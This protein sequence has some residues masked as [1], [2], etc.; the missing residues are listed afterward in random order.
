MLSTNYQYGFCGKI[1]VME[2]CYLTTHDLEELKTLSLNE[3]IDFLKRNPHLK[4]A[5][6]DSLTG[7]CMYQYVASGCIY[8]ELG[9]KAFDI[10]HFYKENQNINF[11]NRVHKIVEDGY[12]GK[13]I[14]FLK[15]G[16]P[17]H[18]CE[19]TPDEPG[20]IITNYLQSQKEC[21]IKLEE[22]E[23]FGLWPES[24]FGKLLKSDA[25]S[26]L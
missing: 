5:F 15:R 11:P 8:P 17:R 25:R 9:I 1:V 3:H 23:I 14:D 10:W 6:S 13:R 24:I 12:N 18:I 2:S 19:L 22:K 20:R 21:K 7:I 4:S 26:S 16:I